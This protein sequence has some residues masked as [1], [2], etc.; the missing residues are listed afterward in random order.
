MSDTPKFD[1]QILG[2]AIHQLGEAALDI[3]DKNG[4]TDRQIYLV[5]MYVSGGLAAANNVP[6]DYAPA[7]ESFRMGFDNY[8]EFVREK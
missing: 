3:A 2:K 8:Q 6:I 7:F 1:G 5:A 4:I